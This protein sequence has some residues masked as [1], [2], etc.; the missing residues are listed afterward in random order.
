MAGSLGQDVVV[1]RVC[2]MSLQVGP[3]ALVGDH[4]LGT[5]AKDRYHSLQEHMIGSGTDWTKSRAPV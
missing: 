2:Q 4:S 3:G 1:E 5:V